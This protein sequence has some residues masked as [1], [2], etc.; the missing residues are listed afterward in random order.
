MYL[1]NSAAVDASLTECTLTVVTG[2]GESSEIVCSPPMLDAAKYEIEQSQP[3]NNPRTYPDPM[4][5][6]IT[7][8]MANPVGTS[9]MTADALT[10]LVEQHRFTTGK[11]EVAYQDFDVVPMYSPD[12]VDRLSSGQVTMSDADPV[13]CGITEVGELSK[14]EDMQRVVVDM[15]SRTQVG[16]MVRTMDAACNVGACVLVKP[17]GHPIPPLN[18]MVY[19]SPA[20][21]FPPTQ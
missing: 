14:S 17:A 11:C 10:S 4:R 5:I 2:A 12:L 21:P 15:V 19:L 6:T 9:R 8:C 20:L 3:H 13:A 18:N 1:A 16:R 7:S